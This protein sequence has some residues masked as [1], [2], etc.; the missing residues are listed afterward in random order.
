MDK[1][2]TVLIVGHDAALSK[3]V[4]SLIMSMDLD[5][6]A[7]AE[8]ETNIYELQLQHHK[9]VEFNLKEQDEYGYYRKFIRLNKRKNIKAHK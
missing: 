4:K 7:H 5:I 9:E 3:A 1:Q 2:T 8:A 6:I